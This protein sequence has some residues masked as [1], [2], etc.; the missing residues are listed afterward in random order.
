MAVS[1][2]N[3]IKTNGSVCESPALHDQEY[4]YFHTAQRQ[5]IRRQRRAA[6]LNLPFQLPLLEDA[7]SIQMAISDVLNALLAH[8]IDH[9]TAGLLLYGL[10]TAAVNVRHIDI[11]ISDFDRQVV[12][13]DEDEND[14]LEEEVAADIAEEKK[15][16]EVARK[17]VERERQR[18][19]AKPAST[20]ALPSKKPAASAAPA[21]AVTNLA[22]GG[23]NAP[24]TPPRK[25]K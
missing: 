17:K 22:A 2:C 6:R 16:E 3:H 8:Q 10:Q 1:L 14:L 21:N 5:R 13:Y 20:P 12:E 4:C 9:K 23:E 19:A 25:Q 11:N 18:E 15:L 7:A 24:P